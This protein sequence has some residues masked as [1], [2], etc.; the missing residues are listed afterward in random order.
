MTVKVEYSRR[1]AFTPAFVLIAEAWHE[2]VYSDLSPDRVGI[3]PVDEQTQVIYARSA[4]GD[5]VGVLLYKHHEYRCVYEITLS[6]VEPSSRKQGV[7]RAMF[8]ALTARA[9]DRAITRIVT[10][11]TANANSHISAFNRLKGHLATVTYEFD[12]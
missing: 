4:E 8:A 12:L 1:A 10:T 7:Y 2:H 5:I 3:P 9:K 6:Y 11:V